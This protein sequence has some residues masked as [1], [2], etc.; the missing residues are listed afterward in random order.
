MP[1]ATAP[2]AAATPGPPSGDTGRA[3]GDGWRY[4]PGLDGLRALAV[5]AVFAYHLDWGAVP[6]GFLGVDTFF[7]LSG[8]LIT[9][10][11]LVEHRR[12]G[13]I[14]L[15]AFWVRRARRLVPAVVVLVAATAAVW[16]AAGDPATLGRVRG[17]ALATLGWVANWWYVT[18]DASYFALFSDPSPFRHT[19]SLAIEEQFYLLWPLVVGGALALGSVRSRRRRRPSL[20]PLAAVCLAGAGLSVWAMAALWDPVDPSRAYYGTDARAHSLLVGALV[21][22]LT[23]RRWAAR[24]VSGPVTQ[25]LGVAGLVALVAAWAAVHDTTAGYYGP[26]SLAV[27]VSAAAVVVAAAQRRGPLPRIL[28]WAPLRAV[29]RVSYGLYLWHW[30]VIVWLNPARTG[31]DGPVLDLLRVA[32][33]GVVTVA[34]YRLVEVPVRY[35][36][37][38]LRRLALAA[39]AAVVLTVGV[40]LV[41]TRGAVPPPF[42]LTSAFEVPSTVAAPP[43]GWFAT[44]PPA[45][46]PPPSTAPVADRRGDP[47]V[48]RTAASLRRAP[49]TGT[50][51][52]VGDS[53]AKT[54][55]PGVAAVLSERGIPFVSVAF[56]GCGV[57]AGLP[58]D[59]DGRPFPWGRACAD[60]APGTRRTLVETHDPGLIIWYSTWET[61]DRLID[62]R[63]VRFGTPEHDAALLA[64]ME[65]A[66]ADYTASGAVVVLVVPASHGPDAPT[67]I[68]DRLGHLGDLFRTLA[69]AHPEAVAGIVDANRWVCP[70]GPPCPTT[71]GGFTARTDG[72]HFTPEAARWIADRLVPEVLTVAGYA[73]R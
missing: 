17:D 44:R 51:A 70:A 45:G 34:S 6:G 39:P 21:A 20:V 46:E 41:A 25:V 8:F 62:G 11:L 32:V 2:H 53:V 9:S 5:A 61:L 69:A 66:L 1:A 73:S 50:V 55:E 48:G 38:P 13:R 67:P 18:T 31:L 37:V 28:G 43:G 27:A 52:L 24:A 40:T 35:R 57:A 56:P 16:G 60:A 15:R 26:G 14:D 3:P 23:H 36:P 47:D 29:G 12:T 10:L 63:H 68:S 58:T 71:L 54:L 4:R 42:E 22:V 19:W 59:A 7:V 65:A 64:D 33:T 49:V 30:P 72:A